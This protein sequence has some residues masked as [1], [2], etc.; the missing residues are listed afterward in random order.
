M[1]ATAKKLS[2]Y[3]KKAPRTAKAKKRGATRPLRK[4]GKKSTMEYVEGGLSMNV[5]WS[6]TCM[7]G[8]QR[9]C[10][11]LR[12]AHEWTQVELADKAGVCPGTI[13]RFEDTSRPMLH[14]RLRTF[15]LVFKKAFGAKITMHYDVPE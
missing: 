14:P 5:V 11:F 15:L 9:R 13:A 8:L 4:V 6:D 2:T 10:Y 3:N 7:L 12:R 1:A